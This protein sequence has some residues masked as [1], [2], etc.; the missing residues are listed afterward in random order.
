MI[1]PN[2]FDETVVAR[3]LE[4]WGSST[5]WQR[6]LWNPGSVA[7][8]REVLEA[9]QAVSRSVL[10]ERAF[11]TLRAD[12]LHLTGA[13]PAI[14]DTTTRHTIASI[15]KEDIVWER[16][17][18][19]ELE[20]AIPQVVD[21]YLSR[22]AALAAEK[23][24]R[25][26]AERLARYVGG[27]LLEGGFAPDYLHRWLS[28]RIKHSPERFSLETLLL[29]ATEDLTNRTP[30]KWTVVIPVL[31]APQA[32]GG[33]GDIWRNAT[34][35][36]AIIED[37]DQKGISP[38][39]NGGF[40]LEILAKDPYA[41]VDR[42]EEMLSRWATRVEFGTDGTLELAGR[43]AWVEGVD[44]P[45]PLVGRGRQVK[46]GALSRE[47][48]LYTALDDDHVSQ[49]INDALQ[50]L[51]PISG[52]SRSAAISGGWATIETL[53]TGG[54]E[55]KALAADRLAA[56]VACSYPRAELTTLSY[57]HTGLAADELASGL[58]GLADNLRRSELVADALSEGRS[59]VGRGRQDDAACERM[60]NVLISPQ[61]ELAKVCDYIKTSILRMYR[62]RNL[63]VHGGIVSGQER[64]LALG[65]AAPLVGAGLDRIIHAW[66]TE[67]LPPLE[68]AARANLNLQLVGS[69]TGPRPTKLLEPR[70]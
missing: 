50:I 23:G 57:I 30:Q 46:I 35:I 62:Q 28:Y 60:R 48:Q 2:D 37:I 26:G 63:I 20:Q 39:Q 53:L 58:S 22:C 9:S 40:V 34:Q 29:H 11:Q 12:A 68:L 13:D 56:I 32:F 43:E 25:P 21:G 42:A 15:L 52:E 69:T 45:I 70:S 10:H 36:A 33:N 24:D 5:A 41:A 44:R 6:S 65:M 54:G 31:A 47:S 61:K 38:R 3:L 7:L 18:Y 17:S 64:R 66:F 49:R 8:L 14:G 4:L 67:R 16:A 51:Q 19:Y 27:H 1:I 59:V 55:N